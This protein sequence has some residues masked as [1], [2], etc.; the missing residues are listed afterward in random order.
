MINP[1][2]KQLKNTI[3]KKTILITA[4]LLSASYLANAATTIT[5]SSFTGISGASDLDNSGSVVSAVNYTNAGGTGPTINGIAFTNVSATTGLYS[6]GPIQITDSTANWSAATA[7]PLDAFDA[8]FDGR[9]NTST[10]TGGFTI[11][12]EL[13][14]LTIGQEYT[15][16]LLSGD[17]ALKHTT[18]FYSGTSSSAVGNADKAEQLINQQAIGATTSNLGGIFTA[19]FTSDDGSAYFTLERSGPDNVPVLGGYV[20]TTAV[21][22]PSSAALIGLGGVA[23]ILRRRK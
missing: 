6:R 4:G 20:L 16:Q 10:N 3:M 17:A 18:S 14:G 19:T 15:I 11:G 8:L 5:G 13:S 2:Q 23:L 1:K 9:A 7:P 21:P 22:E 12:V